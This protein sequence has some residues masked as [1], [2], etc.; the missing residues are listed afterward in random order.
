[1]E[2][3]KVYSLYPYGLPR[4]DYVSARNDRDGICHC[5]ER[6]DVAI[7]IPVFIISR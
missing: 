5:E 4:F 3:F 6:S 7:P 1:M 2:Y